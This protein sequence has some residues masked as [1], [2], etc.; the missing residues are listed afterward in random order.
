MKKTNKNNKL[1]IL[2]I[3]S[4]MTV[5]V[6]SSFVILDLSKRILANNYLETFAKTVDKQPKLTKEERPTVKND[7]NSSDDIKNKPKPVSKPQSKPIFSTKKVF[8]NQAIPFSNINQNDPNLE[9]GKTIISQKGINGLKVIQYL[10]KY[11]DNVEISRQLISASITKQP[12]NQITKIGTK[13]PEPSGTFNYVEAQRV[14]TYTNQ[15]RAKAGLPALKWNNSLAYY[16]RIRAGEIV[17]KF[18]HIRPNGQ[19]YNSLNP[20]LING[21]NLVAGMPV[22]VTAQVAVQKWMESAGHRANILEPRF[23]SMGAAYLIEP[24]GIYKN[25]WVQLFSVQ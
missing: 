20:S 2:T 19:K 6:F 4:T 21:E 11:R 3:V 9:K 22:P 23:K 14:L 18:D 10:I 12:V 16:A 8:V 13:Q 25:Y 24:T 15:E 17:I 1:F 7:I 5:A